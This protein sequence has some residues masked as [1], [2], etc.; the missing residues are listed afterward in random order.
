[1]SSSNELKPAYHVFINHYIKTSNAVQSYLAAFPDASYDAAHI[2]SHRLLRKVTIKKAIED[3]VQ[4]INDN[5]THDRKALLKR[6]YDYE[7][8]ADACSKYQ[9]CC[10]LL[11]FQA[12]LAGHYKD[13]DNSSGNFNLF[14]QQ[15]SV[16]SADN[17]P[18]NG[19]TI[20][21]TGQNDE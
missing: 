7:K 21:V 1:M 8:K 5:L 9:I 15:I 11:D 14:L 10:N 19:K 6:A 13:Q 3:R 17:M 18:D 12:K 16:N 4:E 20:D 2:G